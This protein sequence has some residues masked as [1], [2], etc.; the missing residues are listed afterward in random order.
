ML[1]N[2]V[3]A[4]DTE[5]PT[6]S[7]APKGNAEEVNRQGREELEKILRHPKFKELP[8]QKGGK[9]YTQVAHL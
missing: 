2:Y 7:P 5:K 9:D 1:P 4:T 3:L 6:A 8:N